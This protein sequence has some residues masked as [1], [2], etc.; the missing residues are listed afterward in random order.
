MSRDFKSEEGTKES[1]F[2]IVHNGRTP[3]GGPPPVDVSVF[4]ERERQRER[5]VSFFGRP[6]LCVGRAGHDHSMFSFVHH[7]S[8][9][10][11][12]PHNNVGRHPAP[13][14]PPTDKNLVLTNLMGSRLTRCGCSERTG[15]RMCVLFI[16]TPS[17]TLTLGAFTATTVL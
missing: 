12:T 9:C 14:Y 8:H 15:H 1:I 3:P 5:T 2:D 11:Y 6:S 7:P 13:Y 10:I 4:G 16:D 17:V